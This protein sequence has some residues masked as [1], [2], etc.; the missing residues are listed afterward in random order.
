MQYLILIYMDEARQAA[1]SEEAMATQQ[2]AYGELVQEAKARG[3]W[4]AGDPLL[5]SETGTTLRRR[6]G[7]M[8][9]TDGPYAETK[10]QLGGYFLIEADHLDDALEIAGRI[11]EVDYGAIEVRPVWM[12]LGQRLK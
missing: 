3:M 8:L 2:A 9:V 12:E 5:A 11:P 4:V 7:Q 1:L 10:E 6:A